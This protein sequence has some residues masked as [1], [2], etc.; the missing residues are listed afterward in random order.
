MQP[1]A[2]PEEP[3]VIETTGEEIPASARPR[4]TE[5]PSFSAPPA[6]R[7]DLVPFAST[8]RQLAP[9]APF[10]RKIA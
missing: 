10:W 3:V 8:L 7:S 6:P 1:V 9:E 2:S 5:N 4:R